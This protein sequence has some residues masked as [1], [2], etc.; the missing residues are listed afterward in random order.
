MSTSSGPNPVAVK[1]A[2]LV[3]GSFLALLLAGQVF[4]LVS[5]WLSYAV[6]VGFAVLAVYIVYELA[7]GWSTAESERNEH[8]E[9]VPDDTSAVEQREQSLE[10][11]LTDA[12][13]EAELEQL[14][15]DGIQDDDS[16]VG[17][18]T[19]RSTEREFAD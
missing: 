18:E 9:S 8:T 14:F 11:T 4:R 7:A 13:F 3:G 19:R 17:D 5:R 16:S 2:L 6:L 12:E 15:D 10:G 1:L